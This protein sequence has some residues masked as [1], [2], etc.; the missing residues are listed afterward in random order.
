M[1]CNI[2]RD[3]T[4]WN[5]SNQSCVTQVDE[6]TDIASLSLLLSFVRY[7]YNNQV[8]EEILVYKPLSTHTTGEDNFNLD[9]LY[10]TE[11]GLLYLHRWCMINGWE[12]M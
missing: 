2:K 4:E 3:L 1:S 7:I 8:Q 12:N 5:N 10:V 9:D 6:F 11:I